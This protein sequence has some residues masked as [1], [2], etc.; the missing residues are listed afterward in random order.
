MISSKNSSLLSYASFI[1]IHKA[2]NGPRQCV[3]CMWPFLFSNKP[4]VAVKCLNDDTWPIGFFLLLGTDTRRFHVEFFAVHTY[5]ISS[6]LWSSVTLHLSLSKYERRVSR[7]LFSQCTSQ[8][9]ISMKSNYVALIMS[10]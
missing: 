1:R 2:D 3:S 9:S 4:S 10:R 5:L 7:T 8:S 6:L